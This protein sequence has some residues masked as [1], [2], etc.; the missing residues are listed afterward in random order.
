MKSNLLLVDDRP[1][2]LLVLEAVLGSGYDLIQAHSGQEALK[3]LKDMTVDL[4]LLDVQMPS[5][6]GYETAQRIKQIE[7]C[8][9]IPIILISGIFT[10]DPHVKKGYECGAVDYF[11]KPFD[12]RVLRKKVAIYASLKQKDALLKEKEQRIRELEER[13]AKKAA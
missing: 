13:L 8:Q 3:F 2:N 7:H 9:N 12:P 10:E 5:M 1:D 6:D 4:I 11:T